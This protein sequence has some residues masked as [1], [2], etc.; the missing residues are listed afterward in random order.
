MKKIKINLVLILMMLM[1]LSIGV[2]A[3]V[4]VEEYGIK[5][6]SD[7]QNVIITEYRGDAETLKIDS[8]FTSNTGNTAPIIAIDNN[9]FYHNLSLKDVTIENGI[10]TIR[11]SAFEGC[12][13]LEK[14]TIP[15]SVVWI[16]ADA[17]NG[18]TNLIIYGESKSFAETFA[19]EQGI[20]FEIIGGAKK[21]EIEINRENFIDSLDIMGMGMAGMFIVAIA[22]ALIITVMNIVFDPAKKQKKEESE[23][24]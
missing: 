23:A 18:D 4:N 22:M 21:F 20:R 24:E 12:E 13:N 15:A 17:F 11:N 6:T 14:V 19:S 9:A 8:V 16:S 3:E 7:L 10:Q 5:Y 2:S 1:T